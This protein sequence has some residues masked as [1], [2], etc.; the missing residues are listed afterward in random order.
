M[1]PTHTLA[2]MELSFLAYEEI[3]QKLAAAGYFDAINDGLLDLT[4][5]GATPAPVD[6]SEP[7]QR[8]EMQQ[9]QAACWRWL[10][11][12]A[13]E[14]GGVTIKP[15]G[16]NESFKWGPPVDGEAM[17]AKLEQAVAARDALLK[18]LNTPELHDFARGVVLE[19]AHQ[20]ERWGTE[21]DAGKQPEDWLWL[22]GHLSGRAL[23]HQKEAVRQ[24][25][26]GHRDHAEFNQGKALH[27]LITS[28]AAMANWHAAI[29]GANTAMRPGIE[30]P[31]VLQ[32]DGGTFAH[33]GA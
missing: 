5:L 1:R 30:P 29:S 7:A 2:T 11:K 4:G 18:Q 13:R 24:A 26:Q 25:Q 19:A 21:H 22:A 33:T 14:R 6:T 32:I 20:R 23:A 10:M 27:H 31:D 17:S 3:R 8:P 28:A 15:V 12:E 9:I 16:K